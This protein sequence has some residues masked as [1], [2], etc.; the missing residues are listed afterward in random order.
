MLFHIM[1]RLPFCVKETLEQTFKNRMES[2]GCVQSKVQITS[3]TATNLNILTDPDVSIKPLYCY[4]KNLFLH[5]CV[6]CMKCTS[7][8]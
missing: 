8:V 7:R 2:K 3:C 4:Q 6:D 1:K 5:F